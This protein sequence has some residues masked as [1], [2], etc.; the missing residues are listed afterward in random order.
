MPNR[1]E[2]CEHCDTPRGGKLLSPVDYWLVLGSNGRRI[3]SYWWVCDACFESREKWCPGV[4]PDSCD[5]CGSRL[6][7]GDWSFEFEYNRDGQR[8]SVYGVAPDEAC[9]ILCE[10]CSK[11]T[12]RP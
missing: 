3:P 7:I 6:E 11:A 5:Q 10:A 8:I 2:H 12:G 1:Y 9:R 4:F